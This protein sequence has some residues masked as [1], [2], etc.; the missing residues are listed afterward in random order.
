MR[1]E[2]KCDVQQESVGGTT[3]MIVQDGPMN[4][5][6]LLLLLPLPTSPRTTA[7]LLQPDVNP[8][9][10]SKKNRNS[11]RL[12]AVAHRPVPPFIADNDVETRS[13]QPVHRDRWAPS[14]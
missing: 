8:L 10:T 6:L 12:E 13:T 11:A 3:G 9:K 4:F 2:R 5:L 1:S 14:A 7:L